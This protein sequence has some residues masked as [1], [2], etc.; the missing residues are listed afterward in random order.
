MRVV[1]GAFASQPDPC[2][3][4]RSFTKEGGSMKLM[5]RHTLGILVGILLFSNV[6]SGVC[7]GSS[8]RT[9]LAGYA[10][11]ADATRI[12]AIADDGS[13][14]W[15]DVD[16]GRRTQLQE[17]VHPEV[18]D[19]PILFSPDSARLAV[20]VGSAVHIFDLSTGKVIG[21]LT[22]SKLGRIYQISFSQDG[23][24][25]ATS[26][27]GGVF[28]WEIENQAE[29]ALIPMQSDCNGVSLD[30]DGSNLALGCRNGLQL[31]NLG[32]GPARSFVDHVEVESVLFV[33][34][35]RWIVGVTA[36]P[37]PAQPKQRLQSYRR[38]IV[39]W[40][41][42]TGKKLNTFKT[43]TEVGQLRFGLTIGGPDVLLASDFEDH[44]FEW[45]LDS[46][47][48]KATWKTTAGHPSADGRLLLRNGITP[49]QL[50]LWEIGSPEARARSFLYKSPLCAKTFADENGKVKFDPLFFADGF[51]DDS[52][53]FG[54]F[55]SQGYVA[56]DCTPVFVTRSAHKTEERAGQE[57]KRLIA[58]ATEVLYNGPLENS[59]HQLFPAER[60]V[61]RFPP[62]GG[63]GSFAVLRREGPALVEISS[64][65]LSVALA[66]EEQ[67]FDKR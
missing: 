34:Q 12:A 62:K 42:A 43:D 29:L 61:L 28:V 5:L 51:S 53:S 57:V 52:Q 56:Q 14:F 26:G 31:R 55:N 44:L 7:P 63:I 23:R 10:L 6:S 40:D 30:R 48:L 9:T 58:Q 38:E 49:G 25:L 13:L 32:G 66:L 37:L 36:T 2:V 16:S 60:T 35:D 27:E 1:A 39:I 59:R 19:H 11:S 17:C 3:L 4:V 47:E 67:F 15:W 41:S 18:M 64:S 54:S 50:E 21:R 8:H 33:N 46:G 20:A 45:N 65:S 24:R 22:S